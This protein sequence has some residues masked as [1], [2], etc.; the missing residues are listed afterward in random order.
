MKYIFVL[1]TD[2]VV[3]VMCPSSMEIKTSSINGVDY[4]RRLI[5]FF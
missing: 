1:A 4:K 3:I 2:S 5:P